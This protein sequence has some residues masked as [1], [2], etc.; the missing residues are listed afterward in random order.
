MKKI[1][2]TLWFISLVLSS[3]AQIQPSSFSAYN[4]FTTGNTG[5]INAATDDLD[6]DGKKDVVV[7]NEAI[8]KVSI[9]RNTSTQGS[10]S[11]AA[12]IDSTTGGN[13]SFVHLTDIDGDGKSDIV[14]STGL[15]S[16]V[17]VYRNL[18]TPGNIQL[19]PK[20]TFTLPSSNS[21]G[22]WTGDL[23]GDG[24]PDIVTSNSAGNT[25][26]ILR[27]TSSGGLISFDPVST[28]S[29][30]AL[31]SPSQ[32]SM[33]DLDADTKKDLI[34]FNNSGNNIII[35]RNTTSAPGSISFS[36][37]AISLIANSGPHRGDIADVDGD[38]KPDIAASNFFSK[39]TSLY[40]NTSSPGSISFLPK[41][42]FTT[43]STGMHSSL[44]KDLDNDGKPELIQT[45]GSGL[46]SS[47]VSIF[48]NYTR[49]GNITSSFWGTRIDFITDNEP[50]GLVVEDLD[51]DN[52]PDLITLNYY[53]TN[54]SVLISNINPSEGLVAYYPFTGNTLDSSGF[55]NHGTNSGATLTTDRFGKVN[56]AFYFDGTTDIIT[57]PA[58]ISLRTNKELTL[59]A[60]VKPETKTSN[61]WNFILTYRYSLSSSPF[62]S[63]KLS[64]N[65]NS[66]YNNRWTFG[67]SS[68]ATNQTE[69]SARN[70]KQD[71]NWVHLTA[72]H[73]GSTMKIYINGVLDTSFANPIDSIAY[74]SL[75]LN[76][77]N[78]RVG[79]IDAFKGVIDE[80]RIYNIALN[81][82]EIERLAGLQKT[83]Y[84]KSSGAINL[85]STWGDNPDGTGV[86]PLSFDSAR[87]KYVVANNNNPSLTASLRISGTNSSLV[88]GDGINAFNLI[89]G[90]NDTVSCDSI[91]INSS[92]TVTAQGILS[93]AK[94]NSA[95]SGTVQYT[96][97]SV[98]PIASG[99]YQ[100]L[101][102]SSGLKTLTGN[103]IVKGNFGMLSSL[104]TSGYELTLGTSAT[105]TGTLNR[106][107]GNII[108]RFTRWFAAGTNTG[109]SGLFPMGTETRDL[110]FQVEF[111]SAPTTGGAV[112]AEFISSNPGT[113][114]LPVFDFSNGFIFID[115]A[116]VDG[117]WKVTTA[118]N[119]GTFTARATGTNFSGVNNYSNLRML[120]RMPSGSWNIPGTAL[121]TTG[122]NSSFVAGRSGLTSLQAE[123]GIG[124]DQSQNPLPVKL[125]SFTALKENRTTSVL[126]WQTAFEANAEKFVIQR[127]L[128]LKTWEDR[129]TVK[130]S[131]NSSTKVSYSVSDD[132]RN[133]S[134]PVV[135][136]RLQQHDFNGPVFTSGVVSLLLNDLPAEKST[137]SVYPNPGTS[138]VFLD[139][140]AEK[141]MLYNSLGE[142]VLEIMTPSFNASLLPS[143][144]YYIR[145]GA[146]TIKFIRGE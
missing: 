3:L 82:A 89:I 139:G 108:G 71:N 39:N 121:T 88:L 116:A 64:T 79:A 130:A 53:S 114:G 87:V 73:D 83:Y 58:H 52:I 74:S 134:S 17:I 84:T 49:P 18:S 21:W 35:I 141:A 30:T 10:I 65:P 7:A 96:S 25:F 143:G 12:R 23:D 5:S 133:L 37:T 91:Y 55:E 68:S 59:S 45:S 142:L 145:S 109:T 62:D 33:Y 125:I 95:A 63:Y 90:P 136:Y 119:S 103:I 27:N 20:L 106:V 140:F 8:G 135:Y 144:V 57:V 92:V 99:T 76:I 118:I 93:T 56:S 77:G 94:L 100:N 40:L 48:R 105:N 36:S 107:Q 41:T 120:T 19:S 42:D 60:W 38:G 44:L 104:N 14:V 112:T 47:R 101:V 4:S 67:V 54:F 137:L 16:S 15:S 61:S 69:L 122:S 32:V 80:I 138:E 43:A 124:G 78:S 2:A 131:G 128:N 72:T 9:F 97:S 34:F 28:F 117:Y 46:A 13:A 75:G 22:M 129:T 115:K 146:E 70:A 113:I 24:K 127:S 110:P 66:P 29:N 85:L 50:R 102:I 123:F 126:S 31:S 11:F 86:S 26:S 132:I 1:F 81:Q 6:G 51:G 111:T 98:Q